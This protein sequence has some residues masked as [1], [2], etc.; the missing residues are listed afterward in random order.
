MTARRVR[1][2]TEALR[3]PTLRSDLQPLALGGFL[4]GCAAMN[5]TPPPS[6]FALGPFPIEGAPPIDN[7]VLLLFCPE[8]GGWHTGVRFRH[9]EVST[10]RKA[11]QG[12]ETESVVQDCGV[13]LPAGGRRLKELLS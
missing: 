1:G 6:L 13:V 11:P 3:A 5:K 8:Q 9:A 12:R 10:A 4:L 2:E 7:L